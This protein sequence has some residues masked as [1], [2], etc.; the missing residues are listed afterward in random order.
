M[1]SI[2]TLALLAAGSTAGDL[3]KARNRQDRAALEWGGLRAEE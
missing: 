1:R 2:L 3:E